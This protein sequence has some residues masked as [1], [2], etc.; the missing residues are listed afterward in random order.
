LPRSTIKSGFGNNSAATILQQAQLVFWDFDGVIK[1]TVEI[2]GKAFADLFRGCTGKLTSRVTKHHRANGGV[3][4]FEK[5]PLYCLWAGIKVSPQRVASLCRMF[6]ANV[7]R[8]VVNAPWVEGAEK[9]LRENPFNQKFIL[10]TATPTGEIKSILK[11]LRLQK[12][13]SDVIGAPTPKDRAIRTML[14]KWEILPHECLMI[15]ESAA[16]KNGVNFLLRRRSG[17]KRRGKTFQVIKDFKSLN[18]FA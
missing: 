15:G 11:K 13:F 4:R 6:S 10:V 9:I 5:I 7:V 8:R 16:E 14:Q 1:E 2:K 18:P 3:S 12:S 17:K